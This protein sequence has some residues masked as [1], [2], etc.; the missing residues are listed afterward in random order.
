MI[1]VV[2]PVY[3]VEKYFDACINSIIS[4]TYKELEIILV[5]DGSTDLSGVICDEYKKN[6][7]KR[8]TQL[9]NC[10]WSLQQNVL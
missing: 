10:Y 9:A 4:Q 7:Y 8:K 1:S 3:N 5:D 6:T 2:V